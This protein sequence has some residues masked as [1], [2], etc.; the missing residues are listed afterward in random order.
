MPTPWSTTR[1]RTQP[2]ARQQQVQED[3]APSSNC[4]LAGRRCERM[5]QVVIF[6][7]MR[8]P[9]PHVTGSFGVAELEGGMD[10][11]GLAAAA[12]AALYRAK[13]G[14]RNRVSL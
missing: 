7:D 5:A 8:E 3:D 11:Q 2:S 10:E 9:L 6:K 14:G 12:D 1:M 13:D 4:C